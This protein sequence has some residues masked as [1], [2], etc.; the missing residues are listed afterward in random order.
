[1]RVAYRSICRTTVYQQGPVKFCCASMCR[2]WDL[3]IGFGVKG[4]TPS[5]SRE[6]NL[7]AERSQANGKAVQELVPVDF[8]PWCGETVETCREKDRD[9]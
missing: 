7:F 9:C 6:V 3:L 5:T 4:G 2:W 1:M 8:C